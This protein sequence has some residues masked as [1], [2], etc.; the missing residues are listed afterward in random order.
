MIIPRTQLLFVAV[1]LGV[2]LALP[3]VS[4]AADGLRVEDA[5]FVRFVDPIKKSY[6]EKV[7]GHFKEA[8]PLY[9][10]CLIK[11]TRAAFERLVAEKKLPIIH[12]WELRVGSTRRVAQDLASSDL[13]GLE[14]KF[15]ESIPTDITDEKVL[16]ALG[17]EVRANGDFNFRTWSKKENLLPGVYQVRLLYQGKEPVLCQGGKPC[18]FRICVNFPFCS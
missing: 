12:V 8:P 3:K 1:I 18:E 15:S 13:D 4:G 5:H 10:W 11:G 6:G 7:S 17:I 16:K 9:F 14:L 2:L